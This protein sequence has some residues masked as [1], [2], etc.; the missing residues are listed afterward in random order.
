MFKPVLI[1]TLV[2]MLG[3]TAINIL[4]ME[5]GEWISFTGTSIPVPA[6]TQVIEENSNS[7]VVEMNLDGM[8]VENRMEEGKQ[9][10]FLSV[11]NTDWTIETGK[12]KLPVVR[13]LA[14][15]PSDGS[16]MIK[17][18]NEEHVKFQGYNVYP[19]GKQ[20]VKNGRGGTVYV[21]EDF[22]IDKEFY[23]N[24]SIYPQEM[25]GIPFSGHLRD[26]RLV[27][28]EFHPIRYHPSTQELICYSYLRVRLTYEGTSRIMKPSGLLANLNGSGISMTPPVNNVQTG[29]VNYPANLTTSQNADYVIIAPEPFYSSSKLK[30]LAEWRA[31]YSGLDVAVAKF[32][33]IYY[34][35]GSGNS[36]DAS[37]KSFIQYAYNYWKS[38]NSTD[39]RIRYVLLV[40]DVEY[41]PTHI[42][43]Q[44]SFDELIA[45]DNWYVCV[46]GD[47]IMPDVMIG[48]FPAKNINELNT[49][50]DKTIQYEQNPL[51]GDWANNVLL[52]L[53]TV[54]SL[55]TDLEY[56]RDQYLI[57]SGF[58]ITEVS[59]LDG[60]SSS[61]LIS[62][63]NKGQYIMDYAG[64]GYIN[65][66]E[67]FDAQDIQKLKNDRMLPAI[68]SLACSTGYYDN[69]DYDSLAEAFIKAKNGAIAFFGASRLVSISSVGFGLSEAIASSHIYNLGEITIHAKLGLLPYSTD[70][71]IYNLM[72]DPALD[73]GAPRRRPNTPD[74][75][76]TPVDISF[77]PEAPKQGEQISIKA[78]VNNFGSSDV[79]NVEVEVR[80]GGPNGDIIEKKSLPGIISGGKTEFE[81]SWQATLGMPQ[82]NIYVK[83]YLKDSPIEYYTENNDAQKQILVSLET[84]GWPKTIDDRSISAPVAADINND[85][86]VEYLLQTYTYD[87]YNKLY[88]L[89][90][91]GQPMN[92]W[93]KTIS[94]PYYD[95][96]VLYNNTSAGPV[97]SVGDLDGD[98]KPEIVGALFTQGIY[99]WKNDGTIMPGWPVKVN[100]YA[101]TSPVLMDL[102]SDGKTEVAVGTTDGQ[103]HVLRYDGTDF[104]G[105]PVSVGYKGHLFIAAADLDGDLDTEIIALD[106][107]LPKNYSSSGISTIYAWHHDGAVVSGWPVQMQGADSIL[108]PVTGDLDGNGKTEVI[109][110]STGNGI[111]RVYIWNYD[112]T[113]KASCSLRPDDDIRSAI[114]LADIDGDGDVEIIATSYDYFLYAWHHDGRQAFGWPVSLGDAYWPST[115]VIGDID[116]DSKPEIILTS[117]GGTIYAFKGD[118]TTVKGWPNLLGDRTS[119]SAPILLD[120][121]GD[122]KTELAYTSGLGSIHLLSLTGNYDGDGAEWPMFLHD[123]RHTGS[124]GSKAL[125]PQ[126]PTDIQARDYPDD[127][128][129]S[130]LVSWK[131]S[132]DDDKAAGYFVYRSD[133]VNG[134]YSMI[135]KV[136][137]GEYTYIDNTAKTGIVYWYIV[138]TSNGSN[139]S[140]SPSPVSSYSINDF[141]PKAPAFLSVNNANLDGAIEVYWSQ[142]NETNVA[143]YKIYYGTG[144]GV[145]G[146]PLNVGLTYRFMLTGLVNDKKYYLC[147]TAYDTDG[148]ESLMSAELTATPKDEDTDPPVFSSFYPGK[149]TEGTDFYVKCDISDPSDVYDDDTAY[150]GQGVYLIWDIG[151]F[152]EKSHVVKM[153]RIPSGAFITDKKIPGQ[154]IGSQFV[155]QINAYDNDFD[156]NKTE[157][158]TKG[159]SEKQTITFIPAL[160][161]AYNYPNPAPAGTYTDRTIFRYYVPSDSQVDI[162]IYDIS[163]HLVESLNAQVTG[164]GYNETEWNISNVASGIYMY[165]IEIQLTSG[166]KQ[167][168]KNKLAILK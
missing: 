23:S 37:I 7:V 85:G 168:I 8:N 151:E 113:L 90:N 150:G 2:F 17:I 126:A 79:N 138:R 165:T 109:A 100:G 55:R 9:F 155:Y 34:S 45:T 131:L 21:G 39:G 102:D 26:E 118:G 137:S 104:P 71:E 147:V 57:P 33:N 108:P 129:G 146:D 122:A 98:G 130:I 42:S 93:P 24:D 97:P 140:A 86:S 63:L 144:S 119:A 114:A 1:A 141:A 96:G 110:V 4:G 77:N 10:Q 152:S 38:P 166:E 156:G 153:S 88:V 46:S 136:E 111:C 128:G 92:G 35:F 43:D 160:K 25:A 134:N 56:A 163:G 94:R 59:A 30:Q 158:R 87:K 159:V 74:I 115:P 15:I 103:V 95:Y 58:N 32:E 121:N 148:N 28:L 72:G 47:D 36:K 107:P 19:V 112:G 125:L 124:Y 50:I 16:V 48:R 116:G 52:G 64:H 20:T 81:T 65:K 6:R 101:T 44:T 84:E 29:S 120:S 3:M 99:A 68:F 89:Q 67:I 13:S 54:D 149:V 161:L 143:G 127:K 31:Q 80:D 75:V 60:G 76:I 53:G 105:W 162:N 117:H 133:K 139:I 70:V 66:W 61:N 82:H 14:K 164:A 157:D 167:I 135:G 40:G 12:P 62:G 27:Q 5:T 41:I 142:G 83:A 154:L 106:S 22:T 18:E 132:S 73:L 78:F 145:Y 49:M 69:V 11:P 123:Q 91:N 51:Y